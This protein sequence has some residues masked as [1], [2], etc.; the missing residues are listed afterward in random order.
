M[1]CISV[2]VTAVRRYKSIFIRFIN[3]AFIFRCIVDLLENV[4]FTKRFAF[5]I[6]YKH[7]ALI[8]EYLHRILN[9]AHLFQ[10]WRSKLPE[11]PLRVA[12][13]QRQNN[14]AENHHH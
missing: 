11:H 5:L 12:D 7:D 6:L 13:A 10:V 2:N 8:A 9:N 3:E 1:G 4:L 14:R